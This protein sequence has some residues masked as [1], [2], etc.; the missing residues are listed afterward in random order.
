MISRRQYMKVS[1]GTV[2]AVGFKDL[3]TYGRLMKL[4]GAYEEEKETWL[5][6]AAASQT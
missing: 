3:L 2:V 4:W 1:T 6:R 5:L